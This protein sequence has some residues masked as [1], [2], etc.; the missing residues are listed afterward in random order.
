MN[1][2]KDSKG[3]RKADPNSHPAPC[4]LKL[5][6]S[7]KAFHNSQNEYKWVIH[8][9]QKHLPGLA[10]KTAIMNTISS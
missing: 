4:I 10:K 6:I 8:I 5:A 7:K 9:S 1:K 3:T 2:N